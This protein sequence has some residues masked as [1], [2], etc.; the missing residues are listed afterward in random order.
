MSGILKKLSKKKITVGFGCLLMIAG[1]V[2]F[3]IGYRLTGIFAFLSSLLAVIVILINA[4]VLRNIQQVAQPF[5][6]T[7]K[8]R[9]VNYLVIGGK[10]AEEFSVPED[11]S[12]V[13]ITAPYRGLFASYEILRHTYGILKDGGTAVITA[14]EKEIADTRFSIFDIPLLEMS[15][16]SVK[17]LGLETLARK[18]R[19]PFVIAPKDSIIFLMHDNRKKQRSFHKVECPIK[20]MYEFCEKRGILN[21]FYT[22]TK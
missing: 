13:R 22:T 7:S 5:Y 9:N 3:L 1:L 21:E 17:R 18:S 4:L 2:F 20:E 14:N 11:M 10:E 16:I 19:F 8:I 15:P 12:F 6:A